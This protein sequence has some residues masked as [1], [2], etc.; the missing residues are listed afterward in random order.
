MLLRLTRSR[1]GAGTMRRSVYQIRLYTRQKHLLHTHMAILSER[2]I[3]RVSP[4]FHRFAAIVV[5][6]AV[7]G[8]S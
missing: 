2:S 3:L 5:F 1:Q 4:A 8:Y 6:L 7:L